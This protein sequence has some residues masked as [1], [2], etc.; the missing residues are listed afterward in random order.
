[1]K[2]KKKILVV[3]DNPQIVRL[4]SL[5]LYKNNFEVSVAHDGQQCVQVAKDE[6][7]DLILLDIKMP[8]GGG[9]KAFEALKTMADTNKIPVIFVTAFASKEVKRL[10]KEMGAIDLISKPF[11]GDELM[12]KINTA[13]GY[14]DITLYKQWLSQN[15]FMEDTLINDFI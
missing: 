13:L 8:N 12:E 6:L 7:P 2:N 1:M 11:I 4:I 3:D 14:Q 15:Q 5:R 9:I 10:V